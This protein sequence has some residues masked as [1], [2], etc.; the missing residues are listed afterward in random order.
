M[1][2]KIPAIGCCG[3]DCGLC[4]RFYTEGTSRCPGSGGE[5]FEL[6]HP[7]CGYLGCCA[8]KKGLEVCALCIDFPC[9]R[10]DKETGKTDSFV[11]HR[12]V[13]VN[14]FFIREKGL[15]EFLPGQRERMVLLEKMLADWDDGRCRSFFCL[16]AAHLPPEELHIALGAAERE[17]AGI[18]L[19]DRKAPA[20]VLKGILNKV[21]EKENIQLRLRKPGE[22]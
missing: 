12:K 11:T 4:P 21:A 1:I 9:V 10:F 3:I 8:K 17:A 19:T 5:N 22:V 7:A 2:K 16:A 13:M 20:K 14:Q 6:L 18:V 15:D